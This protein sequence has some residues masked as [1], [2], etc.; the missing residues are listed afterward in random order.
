M[1]VQYI[2]KGVL[3]IC[4]A[5]YIYIN[6]MDIEN[7]HGITPQL[8]NSE[9]TRYFLKIDVSLMIPNRNLF[10]RNMNGWMYQGN[11]DW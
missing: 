11:I 8:D 5:E 6:V 3:I 9:T 1:G 2:S 4:V 10:Y 7:M